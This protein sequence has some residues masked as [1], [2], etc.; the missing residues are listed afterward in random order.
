MYVN[1]KTRFHNLLT[2]GSQENGR[3]GGTEN[4]ASIIGLGKACELASEAMEEEQ[5]KVRALRDRFEASLKEQI[6]E[7]EV[8]GDVENR[9][10]NTTNV[11]IAR[12]DADLLLPTLDHLGLC[13]SAG[14]ACTSGSVNPSHVLKA[15]GFSDERAR[16][17]LRF[18]FSRFNTEAEVEEGVRRVYKAVE[19]VRSVRGEVARSGR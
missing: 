11:S 1:R 16:T 9:L 2:G 10:P 14:S 7:V 18:S 15:M 4:V 3:R 13:C 12:A 6:S 5:T 8:N 19:R 17:S